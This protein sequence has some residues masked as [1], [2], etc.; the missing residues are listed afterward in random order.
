MKPKLQKLEPNRHQAKIISTSASPRDTAAIA[1][2]YSFKIH[3]DKTKESNLSP[4]H[5]SP[6]VDDTPSALDEAYKEPQLPQFISTSNS[7]RKTNNSTYKRFLPKPKMD[8]ATCKIQIRQIV[9]QIKDLYQ[10]GPI[11]DGWLESQS[12]NSS[13]EVMTIDYIKET[14]KFNQSEVTCES[15]RPGYRLCGVDTFGQKWSYPCP[16]EQLASVSI[17]I[18]RY[19]KLQYLLARKRSLEAFLERLQE[20]ERRENI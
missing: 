10:E 13:P 6:Q 15:P 7:H 12:Q 17:A 18:A 2:S 3:S 20:R 16:M 14:Y 8:A 1:R 19:Q 11:V 4:Q 9:Q 5:K